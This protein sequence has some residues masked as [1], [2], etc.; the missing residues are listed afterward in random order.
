MF[1]ELNH[2][3]ITDELI[4]FSGGTDS[5]NELRFHTLKNIGMLNESNE[6][7]SDYLSSDFATE[8]L[9]KNKMK[10]H[11]DTRNIYYNNFNMIESIY[12]FC[13]RRKTKLKKL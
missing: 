2:G 12:S 9:S 3:K 10:I 7:F 5:G 11:L 6:L 1:K 8:V 13:M 4:F